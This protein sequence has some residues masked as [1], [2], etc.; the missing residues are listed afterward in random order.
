MAPSQYLPTYIY[1]VGEHLLV[2]Y[3]SPTCT[4]IFSYS[5]D[6]ITLCHAYSTYVHTYIH[7]YMHATSIILLY[8]IHKYYTIIVIVIILSSTI[9]HTGAVADGIT[10]ALYP[11]HYEGQS[12]WTHGMYMY[13]RIRSIPHSITPPCLLIALHITR[14][15]SQV[16]SWGC[17]GPRLAIASSVWEVE[18]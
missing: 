2:K 5:T 13:V 18:L 16:R 9:V 11:L 1:I 14:N 7:T 8:Y 6:V 3:V 15:P 10:Y 12:L 4:L 17:M